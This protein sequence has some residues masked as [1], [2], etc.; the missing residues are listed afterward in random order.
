MDSELSEE[1]EFKVG[2]HR[3]S[4][5]SPFFAVV[6]DVVTETARTLLTELLHV[7]DLFLVSEIIEGRE[8]K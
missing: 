6:V 4:T 3:G 5:L 2:K 1:L 8:N 7:D